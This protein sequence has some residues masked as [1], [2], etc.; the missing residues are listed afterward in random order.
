[1]SEIA[2]LVREFPLGTFFIIIALFAAVVSVVKTI[3][4]RHRPLVHCDHDHDCDEDD[5]VDEDDVEDDED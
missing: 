1:M 2:S 3:V 5:D 4:N